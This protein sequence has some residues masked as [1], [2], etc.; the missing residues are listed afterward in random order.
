MGLYPK[1]FIRRRQRVY[2]KEGRTEKW[3]KLKDIT[4]NE[5][6]KG[7]K[8]FIDNAIKKAK[9]QGNTK[10]YYSAAKSLSSKDVSIPWTV[11]VMFPNKT[12]YEIAEEIA[13]YFNRIGDEYEPLESPEVNDTGLRTIEPYM[14]ASRLK[15]CKKPKSRVPGDIPPELISPNSDLLALSLIHI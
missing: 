8:K 1:R 3:Y 4:D 6:E 14:I 13:K 5:I 15:H 12:D 2:R 7:K 10:A 11:N 9:K